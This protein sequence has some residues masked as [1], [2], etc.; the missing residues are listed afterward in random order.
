MNIGLIN[1]STLVSDDDVKKIVDA[2]NLQ[3]VQ[4]VCPAHRLLSKYCLFVP[5]GL[6]Y[7]RDPGVLALKLVDKCSA[8]GALGFHYEES[9]GTLDGEIGVSDLLSA[10]GGVLTPGSNGDSL[11]SVCSHEAIEA[12]LDPNC[13]RWL[14]GPV[15]LHGTSWASVADEACDPCQAAGYYKAG[16][17]VSDFILP[18]WRDPRNQKGPWSFTGAVKSALGM[19]A[20]GYL[21]VRNAPGT[22]QDVFAEM[23]N[24]MPWRRG[25]RRW[26]R[27]K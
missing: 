26:E 8:D 21:I 3:L 9:D 13:N 6:S 10:G 12:A 14:D 27:H 7:P 16:V 20:G 18:A 11:S 4:D 19:A 1:C 5:G 23:S 17:W 25:L 22:E 2:V 15:I 24:A